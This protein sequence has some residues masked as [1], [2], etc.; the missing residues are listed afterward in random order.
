MLSI[1]YAYWIRTKTVLYKFIGKTGYIA[2]TND[3][4]DT[5]TIKWVTNQI[6]DIL[7]K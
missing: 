4:N 2:F 6:T 7:Q 1:C 3:R 5:F